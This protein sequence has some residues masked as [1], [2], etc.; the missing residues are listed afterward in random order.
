MTDVATDAERFGFGENWARFL[1][2]LDDERIAEAER[3]LREALGSI[4]GQ[5]FLDLGCGS[6][7]FS[8][9]AMRL[10]AA[11][12]HSI[13]YDPRSVACAAELRRRYFPSATNW[14]VARGDAL[15]RDGMAA[16]GTFDVVYS[17]GVLH[18]TGDMDRALGHAAAAVAP[19]GRLFISIYNDQGSRSRFWAL[20]KRTYNRLPAPLRTPFA[21]A[22]M[23]PR[24]ALSALRWIVALRP[25]NYVRS[26]TRYKSTRGM[27]RW[28]D[29]ID[30]VGGYPFEVARPEEIFERIRRDG[31]AL[32]KLRTCGG[33]L[34]C[35][36][37][38]FVREGEPG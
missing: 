36:E 8:L 19:G 16:L 1:D 29:L 4:E 17:W 32:E 27:S 31:F 9:A 5:T 23:A 33:G 37:F 13:D 34:G 2:V 7:L 10:G 21:V 14:T 38:V 28:H 22:V 11:R 15:D 25:M 3:S 35:N 26:W 20:V 6:G 30:W 12:V 24:E 18:H